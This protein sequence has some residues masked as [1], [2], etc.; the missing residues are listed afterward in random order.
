MAL[1]LL[2]ASYLSS[3]FHGPLRPEEYQGSE[4][5]IPYPLYSET[6]WHSHIYLPGKYYRMILQQSDISNLELVVAYLRR[7]IS[8]MDND[9]TLYG[10]PA[11]ID[12]SICLKS[13][14]V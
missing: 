2:E 7:T 11:Q 10:V 9:P 3:R 13:L 6:G 14:Q 4:Y 12:P 8:G 1:Q 5:A